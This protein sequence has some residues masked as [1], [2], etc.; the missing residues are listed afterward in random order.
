MVRQR[1]EITRSE[2]HLFNPKERN[3]NCSYET[4]VVYATVRY[5]V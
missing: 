1:L 4:H 5:I 2:T 3:C